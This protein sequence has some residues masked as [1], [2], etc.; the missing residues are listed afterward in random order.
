MEV[1]DYKDPKLSTK[2]SLLRTLWPDFPF[3]SRFG[4]YIQQKGTACG[5]LENNILCGI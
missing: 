3:D 2:K 1:I 4:K 5:F